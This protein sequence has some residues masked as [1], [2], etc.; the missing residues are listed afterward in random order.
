MDL[1]T[2]TTQ[3]EPWWVRLQLSSI[4]ASVFSEEIYC[5]LN[6]I[7]RLQLL[8]VAAALRL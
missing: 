1:P 5:G 7:T 8:D 6:V 3:L 2:Q 4:F